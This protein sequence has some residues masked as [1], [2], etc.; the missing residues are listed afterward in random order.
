MKKKNIQP[1]MPILKFLLMT[2]EKP[3]M[4]GNDISLEFNVIENTALV[5]P[6]KRGV[7]ALSFPY[8]K[9]R[10]SIT[11]AEWDLEDS[12]IVM[13]KPPNVAIEDSYFYST[14]EDLDSLVFN[15]EKASYDINTQKLKVDGIP[16]I[17]V[18]DSRI[19]PDG[20]T[21]TILADSRLQQFKNATIIIDTLNGFHLL[22]KGEITVISRN[23]FQGSAFYQV[24]VESDTAEVRF[25]SFDLREVQ[26]DKKNTLLM[27][28]SGGEI[29]EDQNLKIAPGFFYKG[30]IEM[31]AHKKALELNGHIRMDVQNIPN[32]D[33]WIPYERTDS[34]IH[35]HI[36]IKNA[37][38]ED[39]TQGVAGMHYDLKGSIYST[40]IEKRKTPSDID[41]FMSQG[42][43]S[44]DPESRNY[45]VETISKS[46][47]GFQGVYL[48]V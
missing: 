45:K 3:A 35:P 32:G 29:P 19:T 15:G 9:M 46:S 41:F 48:H 42:E 26:L 23:K 18:A 2:P 4:A 31:F 11:E 44:F 6:E 34:S 38:F 10:T 16:Y 21:T 28:V 30:H 7:A 39:G 13:T 36:P 33:F 8:A 1:D 22:T 47:G 27:T 20:N 24:I 12:V 14:R 37:I 25:D 5:K 40:F 43:L 17:Q